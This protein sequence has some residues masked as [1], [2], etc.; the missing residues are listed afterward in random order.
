MRRRAGC[1]A[2][3]LHE[4]LLHRSRVVAGA[5]AQHG[6]PFTVKVD[7]FFGHDLSLCG[8]GVK[9]AGGAAPLQYG[10]QLPAD[11]ESVLHRDVHAL[12]C[13]GAVGMARITRDEN[14]R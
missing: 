2:T 8:V 14:A 11:I 3:M 5:V 4:V 13:F 9:Q 10:S 12:P 7:Q 6:R 1:V